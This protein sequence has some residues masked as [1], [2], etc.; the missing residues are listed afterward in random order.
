MLTADTITDAQIRAL[1]ATTEAAEIRGP[2][3]YVNIDICDLALTPG[4]TR[5]IMTSG[6]NLEMTTSEA[7]RRCAKIIKACVGR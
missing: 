1:R 2:D 5:W 4:S 6:V 3:D 7:R